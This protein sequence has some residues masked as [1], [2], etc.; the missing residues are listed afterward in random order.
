MEKDPEEPLK[1]VVLPSLAPVA[2]T[3][4]EEIA[5]SPNSPISSKEIEPEVNFASTFPPTREAFS[6][7]LVDEKS[8]FPPIFSNLEDPEVREHVKDPD[9]SLAWIL[10][11]EPLRIKSPVIL[12]ALI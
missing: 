11:E 7:P 1:W 4:P 2:L 3:L 9:L 8:R 12:D 6:L 10:P 5:I